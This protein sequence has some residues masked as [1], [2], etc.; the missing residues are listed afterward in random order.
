MQIKTIERV[1]EKKLNDWLDTITDNGLRG[2][3][4]ENILVSGGCITSMLLNEEVNDFDIYLQDRL[5]VKQL[6]EY[7]LKDQSGVI[8]YDWYKANDHN[9]EERQQHSRWGTFLRNIN[10]D[11]I[12]VWCDNEAGIKVE[13]KTTVLDPDHK[14]YQLAYISPNAIS[15]TDQIQIVLRF[16]GDPENI[17]KTFDFVH[18]TNYFTFEKG[19]VTNK[20]A[21]ESILTKQLEYNGS[22]YPLTSV[23]RAKKFVT[24]GWR[25]GAGEYMKMMFQISLLDLQ[26][27]DVLEEQLLGIDVAYFDKLIDILRE[28]YEKDP[29]FKLTPQYFNTLINKVFKEQ[30]GED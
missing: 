11:Q 25:I 8:V 10:Y 4:E 30:R 26:N 29:S 28:R 1:I 19:L 27:V 7:Y 9:S 18:A 17:H 13:P 16:H 15:L 22:M 12:K 21:L 6:A 24:R 3:V 20:A 2:R 14:P 5:V 23:I